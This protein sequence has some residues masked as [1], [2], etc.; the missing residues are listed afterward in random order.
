MNTKRLFRGLG[1]VGA[2]LAVTGCPRG[3]DK[4][5]PKDGMVPLGV[6]NKIQVAFVSNNAHDFWSIAEKGVQK[7]QADINAD[8]NETA[9]VVAE[10][11][12]P[13]QGTASEQQELI[14]DLI[15]KGI[16]GIAVSPNNAANMVPFYRDKVAGANVALVMQDNDL[17][18]KEFG[19]RQ[20]YV[21][22]Q[23]Y[24]AGLA[25]GK[26]VVEACPKGGK[27][28]IFVGRADAQNAI[29]RRQGVLDYL[30]DPNPKT[31]D[32]KELGKVTPWD[33]TNAKV[34]D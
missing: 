21:G 18:E 34:G 8:K 28:A 16:K 4:K 27:L 5:G 33:T 3:A 17:P 25:V 12:K 30:A 7:A 31:L 20:C 9:K 22:T 10:F 19:G 32:S 6:D 14:E 23:N 29:E 2:L 24:R 11:R 15:G 26:L 13:A 1:L